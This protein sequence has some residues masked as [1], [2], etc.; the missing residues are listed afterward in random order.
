[1]TENRRKTDRAPLL[2]DV[3]WAGVAG[4]HEARTS[5][6]TPEGCFIDS[7]GQVTVGEVITFKIGLPAAAWIEVQGEVVYA[8]PSMGFGVRFTDISDSDRKQLESLI[9]AESRE[10]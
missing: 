7:I 3:L 2:L 6:I 1:M 5:D 10:G 8:Y 9:K 4:K